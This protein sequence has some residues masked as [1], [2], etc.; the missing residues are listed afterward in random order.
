MEAA[1]R[2][3]AAVGPMVVEAFTAA[4]EAVSRGR[5]RLPR[6]F[7]G[8]GGGRGYSGAAR[9]YGGGSY[10]GGGYSGGYGG[11]AYRGGAGAIRSGGRSYG[12]SAYRGGGSYGGAYGGARRVGLFGRAR[13]FEWWR[14]AVFQ[15]AQ[16]D[17]GRTAGIPS[18]AAVAAARQAQAGQEKRGMARTALR[19][20]ALRAPAEAFITPVGSRGRP[21]A[22]LRRWQ[23]RSRIRRAVWSGG[24]LGLAGRSSSA[25][26]RS[27]S[28]FAASRS[29]AIPQQ[30]AL[31][32]AIRA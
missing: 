26:G 4:E 20:A 25:G 18:A 9:S 29:A 13:L 14:G 27:G 6:R 22:L 21:M 17:R 30:A 15:R 28:N 1:A 11:S 24:G 12:G 8:F 31:D 7:G 2:T 19:V 16:R 23:P 5:R 32:S 10:R 3:G